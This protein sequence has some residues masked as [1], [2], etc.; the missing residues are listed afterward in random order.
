MD[1]YLIKFFLN[2]D[3]PHGDIT[4]R[5]VMGSGN[6]KARACFL[7][8]EDLVLSGMTAVSQVLRQK[9]PRLKLKIK[10]HDGARLKKGIV[11]AFLQ[12]PVQDILLAE[13]LCLNLL[14]H[15][16]GIA[17]LTARYVAMARKYQVAILD[18]R[19]TT[20]GLR[21]WEKQ[22]VRDG[23]GVNHRT[24]LS[25]QYLIKDNHITVAGSVTKA[26]TAVLRHWEKNRV[27]KRRG[28]I[29]PARILV[30]IEIATLSQLQEALPLGPDIVLLDN[31]TPWQIRE[32]V[33][34]RRELVGASLP[35]LSLSKGGRPF[36]PI[37]EIS[38][39][40]TLKNL[41]K[42]VCLGIERVSVGALTHS[43]PA[44]DI[45][46]KIV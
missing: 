39:G 44:V 20:P 14:Q 27:L 34:I 30:E 37:F 7:A 21:L 36:H 28:E 41:K 5:A 33:K 46:M 25:D 29:Y 23:G 19:K 42:Y 40:I 18:T 35:A 17:T 45:S 15:L 16:S 9:F 2:E 8:K 26:L 13:R 6:P 3:A 11:F 31:M 32:C 22:A 24:S 4:T 1:P 43:A 38:G 12:G 10:K